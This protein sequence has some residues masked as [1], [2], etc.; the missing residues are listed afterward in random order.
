M[1]P[2][3][4]AFYPLGELA[5]ECTCALIRKGSHAALLVHRERECAVLDPAALAAGQTGYL[6]LKHYHSQEAAWRDFLRLMG[7]LCTKRPDSKYFG[8]RIPEDNR[9]IVRPDGSEAMLP[10]DIDPDLDARLTA[11][12]AFI[13]EHLTKGEPL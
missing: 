12:R 4:V 5:P 2:S 13:G 9:M 8:T 10:S 6:L 11:F 7:K 1:L 3:A